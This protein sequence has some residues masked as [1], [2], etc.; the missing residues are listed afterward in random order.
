MLASGMLLVAVLAFLSVMV[1]MSVWRQRKVLAKMPP[2]PTPLPFIGNFLDLDPEKLYNSLLKV[3]EGYGPVFTVHLGPSRRIVMLWGYN[4]VKEALVDQA[5]EFAGRGEQGI[6]DW[7]F[8]GYGVVFS[9]GERAKQ[10]R[11]FSI[12]T[13]RD[14]G[15]GKRGIEERIQEEASFLIQALRDTH[16]A[17][18][19]PTFYMSRTVS[20]VISS[21]VFGDRFEYEDTEFLSLLGM[22]MGSFQF[23]ATSSGQL[24]EMFYSVMKHLPGPQQQAYKEVQGLKNFVAK[25]VQHNQRTLD[26]NCPRDFIDS[27][28]IRMQREGKNPHTEFNMRNLLETTLNLF[29]AGTET[30]STTMRYGFLL[31]MKNPDVA[32][33]MHEEIDQ[34]IG[35]NQ[36]PKYEDHLKMPYTEAVIHEIQRFIDVLPL[37]LARSTTKD[38]KF[39]GFLIPKG[40]EVFPVLGSVL[41][42]PQ[43]FP[44]PDSFNPQHFLDDKGQFKKSDAFMPFSV[45]KRNCFG[46]NLA[47]TEL[48]IFFTTIMQNFLFKSPTEPHD[49]DISPQYV[50]FA[51]I[52]RRYTMS[53][54][55]R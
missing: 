24:F 29:F 37:G 40:T 6:F 52:P 12:A 3:R 32:A 55:P 30:V 15:F 38:V 44:D 45:G 42:D 23:S 34:V 10:L 35:R 19:D 33:K 22:I 51:T 11:R 21:I 13:L 48:F 47:K 9:T 36:Q 17:C 14:F 18:I 31:L 1:L 53:F 16:G 50:G 26:P 41:K 25:K 27:F 54:L 8:K 2:G 46:E 39:R 20:N 43:F 5:E 7:L 49:I 4:A 28:L